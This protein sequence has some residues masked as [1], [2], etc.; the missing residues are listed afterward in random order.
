MSALAQAGEGCSSACAVGIAQVD[1]AHSESKPGFS[2]SLPLVATPRLHPCVVA[3]CVRQRCRLVQGIAHGKKEA[4]VAHCIIYRPVLDMGLVYL[5][6]D[7]QVKLMKYSYIIFTQGQ[8]ASTTTACNAH[9]V[10]SNQWCASLNYH[11]MQ[12]PSVIATWTLFHVF[13][14]LHSFHMS[15]QLAVAGPCHWLYCLGRSGYT[16][17]Q[18]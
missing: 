7:I 18:S 5:T 12:R 11:S 1:T 2:I 16:H 9:V 4:Q 14:V 10:C 8:P 6:L 3:D 17:Q 15:N 13:H